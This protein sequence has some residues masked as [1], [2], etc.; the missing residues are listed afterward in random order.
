MALQLVVRF[1]SI[2]FLIL[3]LI[4]IRKHCTLPLLQDLLSKTLLEKLTSQ[5]SCILSAGLSEAFKWLL[6]RSFKQYISTTYLDSKQGQCPLL[7][8]KMTLIY[9][10]LLKLH[11]S[12]LLKV[13][14][15][16]LY[17]NGLWRKSATYIDNVNAQTIFAVPTFQRTRG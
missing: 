9:S 16:V 11:F 17:T 4:C 5:I 14:R 6:A 8:T 1:L 13:L 2:F 12:I 3:A 7:F 10:I 15:D